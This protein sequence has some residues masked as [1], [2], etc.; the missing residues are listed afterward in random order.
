MEGSGNPALRGGDIP[1]GENVR[2]KTVGQRR[3]LA[4]GHNTGTDP[5]IEEL[6]C[7]VHRMRRALDA[8]PADLRD[9]REAERELDALAALVRWE[10]QRREELRHSLLLLAAAVGS[11]SALALPLVGVREAVELFCGSAPRPAS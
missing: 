6:G 3:T 2:S 1:W 10:H 5:R 7:A 11:V 9:R 4:A 8:H